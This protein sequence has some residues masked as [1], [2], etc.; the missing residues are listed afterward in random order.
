MYE[1]GDA[2]LY[3]VGDSTQLNLAFDQINADATTK[4]VPVQEEIAAVGSNLDMAGQ[5]ATAAGEKMVEAAVATKVNMAEAKGT[6]ALVGEEVGIRLPRHLRTFVAEL[7]GVGAALETAFSGVAVLLLIQILV[8]GAKKLSEFISSHLIFTK[9]MEESNAAIVE[10]NKKLLELADRYN[11]AKEAVDNFGKTAI[12]LGQEKLRILN[13]EIKRNED[14][15]NGSIKG[16]KDVEVSTGWWTK[17]MDIA[18]GSVWELTGGMI[19]LKTSQMDAAEATRAAAETTTINAAAEAKAA[20]EEKELQLKENAKMQAEADEK[21]ANAALEHWHELSNIAMKGGREQ[22]LLYAS[23]DTEKLDIEKT[24]EDKSLALEI[25]FLTSKRNIAKQ[26]HDAAAMKAID[27]QIETFHA[28]H[29]QK[30]MKLDDE[31]AISAK[32]SAK[33]IE[34]SMKAA[35]AAMKF[36]DLPVATSHLISFDQAAA[37]FGLKTLPQMKTELEDQEKAFKVL[38]LAYAGGEVS[39][40]QFDQGLLHLLMSERDVAKATGQSTTAIDKQIIAL[41]QTD[42]ALRETAKSMDNMKQFTNQMGTAFEDLTKNLLLGQETAAQA[43]RKFAEAILQSIAQIAEKKGA[44]QLALGFAGLADPLSGIDAPLAFESA[45]LFF[46]L[47]GGISAAGAVAGGTGGG[48]GNSSSPGSYNQGG[49]GQAT[50]VGTPQQPTTSTN[51]QKF[52][53]GGLVTG[54]TMAVMGE[55]SSD[56]REAALPLDNPQAIEPIVTALTA[57]IGQPGHTFNVQGLVGA[58]DV[59]RFVQQLNSMTKRGSVQLTASNSMRVT[60]R[61]S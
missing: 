25:S 16:Y 2:V 51:I 54:P 7:P 24:Y 40:K 8:E 56:S 57:K 21:E 22:A 37:A 58:H 44:E 27:A 3:F 23:N 32:R 49:P 33:E 46:A 14:I 52:A 48:S 26:Y 61:S 11:K 9:Q 5:E 1:V 17:A 60:R 59:K 43:M 18:K 50:N 39:V 30:M 36:P 31:G 19:A 45:A 6:I 15:L 12:Q 55:A 35:A 20:K 34:D 53:A 28:E 29:I 42:P 38:K 41:K 10:Q 4:L 13:D 47:A